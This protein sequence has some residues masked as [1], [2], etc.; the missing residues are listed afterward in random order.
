MHSPIRYAWGS[1]YE[2]QLLLQDN[3]QTVERS[4]A[5]ITRCKHLKHWSSRFSAQPSLAHAVS[6]AIAHPPG[7]NPVNTRSDGPLELI[8][9]QTYRD[10]VPQFRTQLFTVEHVSQAYPMAL[11]VL[12]EPIGAESDPDLY[13]SNTCETPSNNSAEW[14]SRGLGE[15]LGPRPTPATGSIQCANADFQHTFS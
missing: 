10:F 7:D 9:G 1:Y 5:I 6:H 2:T 13:I 3:A 11:N 12:A 14:L 15:D 4:A 8:L